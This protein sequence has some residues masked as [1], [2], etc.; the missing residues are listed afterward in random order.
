MVL[1]PHFYQATWDQLGID[2]LERYLEKSRTWDVPLWLGE[3]TRFALD[4]S[5]ASSLTHNLDWYADRRRGG[6]CGPTNPGGST[7][8]VQ[9]GMVDVVRGGF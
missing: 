1:A 6:R 3:S 9:P 4:P 7:G 5:W 8:S 2:R